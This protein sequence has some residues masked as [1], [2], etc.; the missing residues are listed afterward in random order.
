MLLSVWGWVGWERR[1][2]WGLA[3][4]RHGPILLEV[5]NQP[6]GDGPMEVRIPTLVL[7][8]PD[9]EVSVK[10]FEEKVR[11]AV[12]EV[13]NAAWQ[14]FVWAVENMA[15]R[16]HPAGDLWVKDREERKLLTSVGVVTFS[17]RRFT[18]PNDEKS[19]LLFDKR[20]GL[21][22]N[23]RCTEA[24]ERLL[25]EMGVEHTYASAARSLERVWGQRV[26]AMRVWQSVQRLGRRLEEARKEQRKSFFEDGELPGW[27]KP[28]PEYVGTETDSV[29]VAAW[30]KNNE[31]HEV[32]VGISYTG[33]EEKGKGKS[34]R[35]RLVDKGVCYGVNGSVE[36]GKDFLVMAQA[37]HNVVDAKVGTYLSD[38]AAALRNI[39]LEHFPRH[40]R[41][42]D[43]RHIRDKMEETYRVIP[44]ERH[45]ELLKMLYGEKLTEVC[46]QIRIDAEKYPQRSDR[47]KELGTYIANA[48]DDLYA[49]RRLRRAGVNL[50]PRLMGSG[51]IERNVDTF[52]GQRMK[53]RGMGWS[54]PGIGHLLAVKSNLLPPSHWISPGRS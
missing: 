8:I 49:I 36:F 45:K 10:V 44:G 15:R 52:V 2:V 24:A 6:K 37:R 30:R 23:Q 11:V 26:N 42:M 4:R 3:E 19:F 54:K 51:G 32:Y 31:R 14:G 34:K 12:R 50:P 16:Q 27:E 46:E 20:V 53:R 41:G 25:A 43:W 33:K 5:R 9:Q 29:M 17:R 38:G 35:C 28:A 13:A 40:T 39:Q 1:G 21:M 7:E 22:S 48:G 47:L 18:S